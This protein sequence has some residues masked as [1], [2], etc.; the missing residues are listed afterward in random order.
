M[1]VNPAHR[2]GGG[3]GGLDFQTR[4]AHKRTF[5]SGP[6]WTLVTDVRVTCCGTVMFANV[7]HARARAADRRVHVN[8]F[9]RRMR[10]SRVR[11]SRASRLMF[12]LVR[13]N[14]VFTWPATSRDSRP[15]RLDTRVRPS[16]AAVPVP[17]RNTTV[18][19]SRRTGRS[20][21]LTPGRLYF[22]VTS[23]AP[24]VC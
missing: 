13:T 3:G 5:P 1:S 24:F 9:T 6:R 19:A 12:I 2:L 16:S 15:P 22:E 21:R 8:A 17:R 14:A 11:R 10:C 18:R 20:A 4:S 7:P 23:R